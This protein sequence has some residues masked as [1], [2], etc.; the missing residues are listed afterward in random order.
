[1]NYGKAVTWRAY[2]LSEK[3]NCAGYNVKHYLDRW[4]SMIRLGLTNHIFYIRILIILIILIL[5]WKRSLM[6]INIR[7]ISL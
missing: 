4:D 6:Q 1:M 5:F 7:A 2:K 3:F